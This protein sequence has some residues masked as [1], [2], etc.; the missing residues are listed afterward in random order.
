MRAAKRCSTVCRWR[1]ASSPSATPTG[2]SESMSIDTKTDGFFRVRMLP[3][4]HG[5]CLWVEYG[6]GKR[7]RR[8]LIDGGPIGA[9]KALEAQVRSLPAGD[10]RIELVV[11]THVDTDHVDGL[12]R[13]FAEP[14]PWPF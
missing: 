10:A 12:V 3:A 11:L 1:C 8:V 6:T 7:T 14:P 9:W 4:L 2:G 5:D 13:L